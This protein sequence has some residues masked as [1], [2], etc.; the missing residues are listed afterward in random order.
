MAKTLTL[1]S[2]LGHH[3]VFWTYWVAYCA[4]YQCC[5]P[6]AQSSPDEG[7][8]KPILR[9]CFESAGRATSSVANAAVSSEWSPFMLSQWR[10]THTIQLMNF[11]RV[12]FVQVYYSCWWHWHGRSVVAKKSCWMGACSAKAARC[13][14]QSISLVKCTHA[15]IICCGL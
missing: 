12:V 8:S 15:S 3:D 6:T 4:I 7:T 13:T 11:F 1:K 9:V 5:R 14:S 10:W 2:S